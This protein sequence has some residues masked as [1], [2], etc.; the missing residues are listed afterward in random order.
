MALPGQDRP[1]RP[2]R[3]PALPTEGLGR[4][5]AQARASPLSG[6]ATLTAAD[7]QEIFGRAGADPAT[8]EVCIRGLFLRLGGV[9]PRPEA[10]I[11]LL[12]TG[13]TRDAC[14][15]CA[16]HLDLATSLGETRLCKVGAAE[17]E[18]AGSAGVWASELRCTRYFCRGCRAAEQER[19]PTHPFLVA[20]YKGDLAEAKN[21]EAPAL[22]AGPAL[23]WACA[24]GNLEVV[25]WLVEHFELFDP[26][27]EALGEPPGGGG[28]PGQSFFRGL[29]F[30][31]VSPRTPRALS[32]PALA[33]AGPSREGEAIV[34]PRVPAE[35]LLPPADSP[36]AAHNTYKRLALVEASRA[37][38]LSVVQ[39]VVQRAGLSPEAL[40]AHYLCALRAA[41]FGFRRD[42]VR[43]F[44]QFGLGS[45]DFERAGIPPETIRGLSGPAG[46]ERAGGLAARCPPSPTKKAEP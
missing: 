9:A 23:K 26:W 31:V 32:S 18:P 6:S 1:Q 20:C 14:A 38:H 13:H 30:Y 36:R 16:A 28:V 40:R 17:S 35:S 45:A 39:W 15:R 43:W 8:A 33:G 21:A 29:E 25:Q 5:T 24:R 2:G 12:V 37:G 11:D 46:P 44:V 22:L 34:S 7:L 19:E 10:L 42:V 27:G 4:P 41:Y 3:V